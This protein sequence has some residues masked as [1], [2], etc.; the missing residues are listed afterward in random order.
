MGFPNFFDKKKKKLFF[1]SHPPYRPKKKK[2]GGRGGNKHCPGAGRGSFF[3][4]FFISFFSK[5]EFCYTKDPLLYF[6]KKEGRLYRQLLKKDVA[7]K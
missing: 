3:Q 5:S 2:G 7:T 1:E 6:L 4:S